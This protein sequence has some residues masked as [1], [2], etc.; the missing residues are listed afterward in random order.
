MQK[1]NLQ[2]TYQNDSIRPSAKEMPRSRWI[3]KRGV[4]TCSTLRRRKRKPI[5]RRGPV[6]RYATDPRGCGWEHAG[7]GSPLPSDVPLQ[8]TILD[9][10]KV[11]SLSLQPNHPS[12]HPSNPPTSAGQLIDV[13]LSYHKETQSIRNFPHLAHELL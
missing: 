2:Q 13:C 3:C 9:S 1:N 7:P 10:T 5:F 12:N 6:P 4:W 8:H 11:T